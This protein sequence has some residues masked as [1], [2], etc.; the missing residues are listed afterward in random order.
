MAR[1][2]SLCL[3]ALL[4]RVPNVY[5]LLNDDTKILINL[6]IEKH[7]DFRIASTYNKGSL[8]EH[9]E[10]IEDI[11]RKE[12]CNTY[13]NLK[14]WAL[15]FER[16][17]SVEMEQ[18]CLRAI[19]LYYSESPNF[20]DANHAITN[21]MKFIDKFDIDTYKYFIE[22]SEDN[23]QTYG[24]AK[25]AED[26]KRIKDNIAKLDKDF[27]FSSYTGFNSAVARATIA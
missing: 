14:T 7:M 5:A 23:R 24:R 21:V 4:I 12:Y 2:L 6:G 18:R 1:S 8:Q 13:I 22:I 9:Y 26:Y 27:D 20:D 19:C 11:F 15:L 17:D 10:H 16:S 25:A 3:I